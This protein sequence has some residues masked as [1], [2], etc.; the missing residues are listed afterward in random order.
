MN[1]NKIKRGAISIFGKKKKKKNVG[2]FKFYWPNQ[3]LDD[4]KKKTT[5][6]AIPLPFFS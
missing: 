6:I 3:R 1:K 4:E 5:V 2:V